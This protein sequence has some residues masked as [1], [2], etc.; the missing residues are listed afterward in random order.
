MEKNKKTIYTTKFLVT[1]SIINSVCF[2]TFILWPVGAVSTFIFFI[3]F[4]LFGVDEVAPQK[5]K[6]LLGQTFIF[7]VVMIVVGWGHV[8]IF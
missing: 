1:L 3:A 4:L 6:Q 8:A 5:S 2:F 7:L